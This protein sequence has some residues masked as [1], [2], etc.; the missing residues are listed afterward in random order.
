MHTDA[1]EE[2]WWSRGYLPHFDA[3]NRVQHVTFHLADGLPAAMLARLADDLLDVPTARRASEQRHRIQAWLD[4]GHG[5]CLLR[6]P[7]AAALVQSALLHFDSQRYQLLAWV[8]MPNHVHAVLRM[9]PGHEL[10]STVASWKSYTGRRLAPALPECQR[11]WHRE[12]WDRYV[13]DETHL[14]TVIDYV[15]NNPVKARLAPSAEA[16]PWSSAYHGQPSARHQSQTGPNQGRT[17]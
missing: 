6:E 12:Y 15:H 13:R 9:L 14:A 16:W 4:T 3:V 5:C 7:W 10:R 1:G 8:V 17:A 11:V 2:R